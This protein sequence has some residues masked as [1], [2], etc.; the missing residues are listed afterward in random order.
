M[1]DKTEM[2]IDGGKKAKVGGPDERALLV[3]NKKIYTINTPRT[4]SA[5]S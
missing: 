3:N 5:D 4:K 2:R 1:I